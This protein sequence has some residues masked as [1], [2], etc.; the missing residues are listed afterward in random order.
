MM[1]ESLSDSWLAGRL[2]DFHFTGAIAPRRPRRAKTYSP[3][4]NSSNP[5]P[6]N[7]LLRRAATLCPI[8]SL[9]WW[10]CAAN[11]PPRDC[12]AISSTHKP[13]DS[14]ERWA[15]HHSRN[16]SQPIGRGQR[17]VSCHRVTVSTIVS[18][19]TGRHPKTFRF[20]FSIARQVGGEVQGGEGRGAE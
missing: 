11:R 16:I 17:E 13:R 7:H 8:H 1:G 6:T 5:P 2:T 20:V 14:A 4:K 15:C 19:P 3:A 10:S 18:W 9:G 12:Q